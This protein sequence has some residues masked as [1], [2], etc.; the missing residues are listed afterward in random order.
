[1][2]A[3]FAVG[4]LS[5]EAPAVE[6]LPLDRGSARLC[7]NGRV[8]PVIHGMVRDTRSSLDE[9]TDRLQGQT[10][11]AGS[12][13]ILLCSCSRGVGCTSLA[14]AWATIASEKMSAAI[15]ECDWQRPMLRETLGLPSA[16]GWCEAF[17]GKCS[18]DEVRTRIDDWPGLAIYALGRNSAPVQG[19]DTRQLVWALQ[20]LKARHDLVIIDGGPARSA[21]ERYAKIADHSILVCDANQCRSDDWARAWDRLEETGANLAGIIETFA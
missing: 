10:A 4:W 20:A 6:F 2:N 12:M 1:M 9:L 17:A 16:P 18:W 19:V 8:S 13:T 15:I 3:E 7:I 5:A 11:A 21:A 14:V